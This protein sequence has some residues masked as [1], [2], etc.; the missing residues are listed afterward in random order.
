MASSSSEAV[1]PIDA[2]T[3]QAFS[4]NY[5]PTAA[6]IESLDV[7][8]GFAVLAGLLVAVLAWGGFSDG[9]QN[10]LVG[11][12]TSNNFRI[13]A[14]LSM[15][16]EA[17]MRGLVTLAFGAGMILF[18]VRPHLNAG[19]SNG[20]L[21]VRRNMWLML[22]GIFNAV[23]LLWPFDILFHLGIIGLLLFPFPRMNTKGLMIAV[24]FLLL[25]GS[26]KNLWYHADD[27]KAYN[28]FLLVEALEKKF[29]KDSLNK[30]SDKKDSAT[31]V[32]AAAKKTADSIAKKAADSAARK[33]GDTLT[34]KQVNEK[35]AWEGIAKRYAYEAKNDS[36]KINAMQ[37]N[38]Y[39]ENWSFLIPQIQQR[40]ANWFYRNGVWEFGALALL[41]MALFKMGF[42]NGGLGRNRY[43]LIALLGVGL[44]LLCGWYRLVGQHAA[45]LDY[46]KFIKN[47]TLPFTI[48]WPFEKAFM[49]AGYAA[50]IVYLLE[51]GWAKKLFRLLSDVGRLALTNYIL[52][53]IFL[54]IF[55]YGYGMGYFARL[56]HLRLYIVAA[57][58]CLV[59]IVFSVFWLRYFYMGP[60]EWLLKSLMYKRRMPFRRQDEVADFASAQDFPNS[61]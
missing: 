1:M 54:S 11:H 10:Y 6:R 43:L 25:I 18:L 58:L 60:I 56:G 15:L 41:G 27:Q 8:K 36:A 44:G 42:F 31:T 5:T 26:G 57:E 30:K 32:V 23:M 40:E 24:V 48:L 61:F 46:T 17:K 34:T 13:Y 35:K 19:I 59:Q 20:E 51:V 14:A 3:I 9:M 29:S 52:Q 49:V 45:I 55:F 16:L 38:S 2:S 47:R 50:L 28:K 37:K 4:P 53:S 12:P 33:A 7:V 22:F 39:A 21:L